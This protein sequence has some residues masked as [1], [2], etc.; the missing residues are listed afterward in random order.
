MK[1]PTRKPFQHPDNPPDSTVGQPEPDTAQNARPELP[2]LAFQFS[3]AA[4]EAGQPDVTDG[5]ATTRARD[6]SRG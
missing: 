2:T 5:P 1:K 3:D 4:Q 6:G